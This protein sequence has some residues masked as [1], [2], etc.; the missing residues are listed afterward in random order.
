[1]LKRQLSHGT[2]LVLLEKLR[3]NIQ[4]CFLFLFLVLVHFG[5]SA[6]WCDSENQWEV[7]KSWLFAL[8]LEQQ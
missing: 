3:K 5:P 8:F 1:M 2:I 4:I 6:Q 7:R